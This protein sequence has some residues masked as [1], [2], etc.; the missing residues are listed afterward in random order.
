MADT[1]KI[2]DWEEVPIDDWE[3]VPAEEQKAPTTQISPEELPQGLP[4]IDPLKPAPVKPL[5]FLKQ[6]PP[7]P[8]EVGKGTSFMA[9]GAKMSTFGFAPEL[10]GLIKSKREGM[11]LTGGTTKDFIQR[12]KK[13]MKLAESANPKTFFAGEL[14]GTIPHLLL[15]PTGSAVAGGKAVA[16]TAATQV[17]NISTIIKLLKASKG[18]I[19]PAIEGMITAAGY[20]DAEDFKGRLKDA[21][22]G[23]LFNVATHGAGRIIKKVIPTAVKKK[24]LDLG[25][26]FL[27]KAEHKTL[28]AMGLFGKKRAKHLVDKDSLR[29]LVLDEK[30]ARQVLKDKNIKL[31]SKTM[32]IFK[33]AI[34]E[35]DRQGKEI[36]KFYSRLDSLGKNNLD[37]RKMAVELYEKIRTEY[38]GKMDRTK[39]NRMTAAL[40]DLFDVPVDGTGKASFQDIQKFKRKL[41]DKIKKWGIPDERYEGYKIARS[42]LRRALIKESI[43]SGAPAKELV[44]LNMKFKNLAHVDDLAKMVGNRNLMKDINEGLNLNPWSVN[45]M[46]A[47]PSLTAATKGLSILNK[48]RTGRY[49]STAALMNDFIGKK[50][51]RLAQDPKL[52]KIVM[53]LMEQAGEGKHGMYH[54]LLWAKSKP[55]RDTFMEYIEE[56]K[57][58]KE[59][60]PY[61]E[62]MPRDKYPLVKFEEEI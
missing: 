36:G 59:K 6:P 51:T 4:F 39:L 25:K 19:T 54:A 55:Y 44:N 26:K 23:G 42:K 28:D 3:E 22:F 35:S 21:G 43:K 7:S 62:V 33:R 18:F 58:K 1:E 27:K 13:K 40:E 10:V 41:D 57:G 50:I 17:K 16:G 60:I 48:F 5:E 15:I 53:G 47:N 11:P 45:Y 30:M 37:A 31:N 46:A 49:S 20:S 2:T 38:S 56:E 34:A 9:G 32:N 29:R 14:A 24:F 52:A 8:E 61:Q 12:E